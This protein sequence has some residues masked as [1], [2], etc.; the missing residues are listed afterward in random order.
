MS[1]GR[2]HLSEAL[3]LFLNNLLIQ[4]SA[5]SDDDDRIEYVPT[6][7]TYAYQLMREPCDRLRFATARRVLKKWAKG[8]WLSSSHRQVWNCIRRSQ[9]K[10]KTAGI[11]FWKTMRRIP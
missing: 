10:G 11:S 9:T 6:V 8:L 4:N 3:D 5:V 7:L 1:N 2:A